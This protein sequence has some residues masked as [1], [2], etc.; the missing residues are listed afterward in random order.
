MKKPVLKYKVISSYK[1]HKRYSK[2]REE[3]ALGKKTGDVKDEIALLT[4]L[5]EKYDSENSCGERHPVKVLSVLMEQHA[6]SQAE[7]SRKLKISPGIISDILYY[8]RG[9]SK[10]VMRKLAGFFKISQDVFN[11]AYKLKE[12]KMPYLK[13]ITPVKRKRA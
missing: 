5:I 8:R 3:L 9:F 6:V 2:I 7:L 11:R 10:G 4:V 1:Q 13:K 12:C